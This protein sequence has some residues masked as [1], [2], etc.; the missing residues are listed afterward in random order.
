MVGASPP[1]SFFAYPDKPS[2]CTP[3]NCRILYLAHPNEDG[4]V[5]LEA[6]AEA[7]KAPRQPSH[8]GVS[9]KPDI[10]TGPHASAEAFA[11]LSDLWSGSLGVEMFSQ[12]APIQKSSAINR[13]Y[14]EVD[15]H[16]GAAAR[17]LQALVWPQPTAPCCRR[18]WTH[19]LTAVAWISASVRSVIDPTPVRSA[20]QRRN[21]TS[22]AQATSRG[23]RCRVG[24]EAGV[25]R[26]VREDNL[27]LAAFFLNLRQA[28]IGAV[29][30]CPRARAS[31]AS[32]VPPS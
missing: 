4:T 26:V 32:R 3:E 2:W 18:R 13:R 31:C 5:A 22:S 29:G 30:F 15:D 19:S 6:L 9:S 11:P 25:Q 7:V 12:D 21:R 1:V 10:P 28:S 8:I 20:A 24:G 16:G 17:R 14:Q 27:S 23:L